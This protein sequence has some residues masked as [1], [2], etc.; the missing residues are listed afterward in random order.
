MSSVLPIKIIP[1]KETKYFLKK[2]NFKNKDLAAHALYSFLILINTAII[3]FLI[4]YSLE[5]KEIFIQLLVFIP[6]LKTATTLPL[7]INGLGIR[8]YLF[9]QFAGLIQIQAETALLAALIAYFLLLSHRLTG[10]AP[11]FLCQKKQ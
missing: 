9:I 10:I 4:F 6:L 8:E 3:Y 5:N 1:F 2:I 7:S 11:F